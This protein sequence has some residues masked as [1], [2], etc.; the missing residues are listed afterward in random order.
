MRKEYIIEIGCLELTKR[1]CVEGRSQ[2]DCANKAFEF[3]DSLCESFE[4]DYDKET[5]TL[6]EVH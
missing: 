2:D 3:I 6:F 4:V 5:V 1:V